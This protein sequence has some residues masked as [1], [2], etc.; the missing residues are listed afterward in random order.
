MKQL[1]K[2]LS[3]IIPVYRGEKTINDL[4]QDLKKT[5]DSIKQKY[6]IIFVEDCGGDHS[7]DTIEK[8]IKK[9]QKVTG[10][11]FDKNFGQHNA[12]LCGIR[13]A[14]YDISITMDDDLQNLPSEVP[15]LLAE[16]NRGFDVVYGYPEKLAHESWRNFSSVFVKYLLRIAMGIKTARYVSAY[17]AFKTSLR[18]A[19][20]TY[21]SPNV[22]I[23]VLLTW[24]TS[25]FS[26]VFVKH[27]QRQKGASGY[28]LRKLLQHTINLCTGFSALP[29]RIAT[30]LG[31]LFTFFGFLVLI[32]VFINYLS[33]SQNIPGF[34]FLASLISVFSGVQLM[35]LGIFGEYLA[36]I[37]FRTMKIPPYV[38]GEIKN[39]DTKTHD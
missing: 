30:F 25:K 29:L 39:K 23:D 11:R 16:I 14:C 3:V 20:S 26:H 31:L 37:H 10:I 22:S 17:R 1:P 2:G 5:L 38:I 7:W 35:T 28:T 4:Y 19:F 8:I 34:A 36:K 9:D 27:S 18:D 24:G 6:E 15:K 12:L 13:K 21:D 33:N 32:Y